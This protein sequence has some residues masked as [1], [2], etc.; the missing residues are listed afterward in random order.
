MISQSVFR[1]IPI[2]LLLALV[3]LNTAL[4]ARAH[5]LQGNKRSQRTAQNTGAR[6]VEQGY[7]T[8]D[9]GVRLFY[10]K[11]GRGVRTVIIPGR[12]FVFDDLKP[13]ADQFTIV[14]SLLELEKE[15]GQRLISF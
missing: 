13:L 11:A 10:E 9:D 15:T 3:I 2:S 1:K 8:I 5:S 7:V 14:S 6:R 4:E 12:L